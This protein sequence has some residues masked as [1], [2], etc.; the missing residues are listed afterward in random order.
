MKFSSPCH[1]VHKIA[2]FKSFWKITQK[3]YFNSQYSYRGSLRSKAISGKWNPLKNHEKYFLFHLNKLN[4]LLANQISL[5]LY[6]FIKPNVWYWSSLKILVVK[7]WFPFNFTKTLQGRHFVVG[8]PKSFKL[9]ADI[10]LERGLQSIVLLSLLLFSCVYCQVDI[11]DIQR[12]EGATSTARNLTIVD[13]Y[14]SIFK[15]W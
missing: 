10:S 7:R 5:I 2:A 1:Y 3:S 14:T 4:F 9:L 15:I 13:P 12:N 8:G 11:D 6:I